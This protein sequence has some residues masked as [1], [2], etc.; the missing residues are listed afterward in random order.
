MRKIAVGLSAALALAALAAPAS[1][2]A[3]NTV[4]LGQLDPYTNLNYNDVWGYAAPN[5]DEYALLGTTGGTAVIDTTNPAQPVERGFFPGPTSTWRDIR[6]YGQYA[7]VVTEGGGGMQILDLS[8]PNTPVLVQTWGAQLWGNAHNICIDTATGMIVVIGTN[9]GSAVIDASQNPANPTF[10]GW[11]LTGSQSDYYHDMHIQNGL[12]HGAMIYRGV[13]RVLDVTTWPFTVLSERATPDTFTHNCWPNANDTIAVTTD[14]RA[15]A[16]VR[17]WNISN[18]ANPVGLGTFTPNTNSI[19]HNAFLVGDVCHVSWYTE[20]YRAIDIS[21]PN[22]PVEIGSY[23]TWPGSSGGFNGAW[24]CYPFQPSG[25]VYVSDITTGLYIVRLQRLDVSH[26]PLSDTIDESGPYAVACDVSSS[27]PVQSVDL[28]WRVDGGPQT[29][30]AMTPSAPAGHY[31]AAIPGQLAPSRVEYAIE[32]TAGSATKRSPGPNA[33]HSFAVG[34]LSRAFFDDF[35]SGA[36][37][38]THGFVLRQD[39]WQLGAPAGRGGTVNGVAFAD[40][41]SAYSG[42]NCWGNDLGGAG[43]NGI[44]QPSVSNWLQSPA[45]PTNGT[46]GLRLRF[47]RWLTIESGQFDQAQVLVNNQVVWSNPA[48]ANLIDTAWTLVDLDIA[49]IANA[50]SSLSVRFTLVTDGGANFGGWT[51]D[52]FEIYRFSD[53]FPPEPYGAASPGSGGIE[54]TIGSSGEPRIG[55]TFTLQ[56]GA[57]L[58]GT[59]A[60]LGLAPAPSSLPIVGI[61]LLVDPAAVIFLPQAVGGAVGTP[62]AG[63]AAIPIPIPADPLLDNADVFHQWLVVDPGAPG[64]LLSASRGL[65]ARVCQF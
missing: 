51:L 50:A 63:S 13:Y 23:D 34:V 11:H 40:P 64:G 61:T 22:Q 31:T 32:A 3:S 41:S 44:Y 21:N 49:P 24:G 46:Q 53:C 4:L 37:G 47:R 56:G 39:D 60:F 42:S 65:R 38:W 45:I 14:E 62:G 36:N 54:P 17:F 43:F 25:N 26:Q 8:N 55:T 2:Q 57:M 15:G 6:T 59:T 52:D 18:P 12:A 29:R 30:I 35:E 58:G 28:V 19:P 1:S 48:S 5:G 33:W 16:V 20:G 10:V 9:N 7:Y 27:E